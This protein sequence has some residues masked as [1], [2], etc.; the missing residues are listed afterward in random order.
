MGVGIICGVTGFNPVF[1]FPLFIYIAQCS[2]DGEIPVVDNT[3]PAFEE[4]QT[5]PEVNY[6]M[7]FR[8]FCKPC[9]PMPSNVLKAFL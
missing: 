3:L 4:T 9:L 5:V 1:V 7:L 2:N 8:S 6:V